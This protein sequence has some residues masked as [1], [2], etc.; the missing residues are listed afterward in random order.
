MTITT[1]T[2]TV[3]GMH[4]P[5]CALLIDDALEDLPGVISS[6]TSRRKG[7]ATVE[8]NPDVVTPEQVAQAIRAVGYRVA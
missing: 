8:L 3:S 4:C 1:H 7:T 5:G 2:F 6:R